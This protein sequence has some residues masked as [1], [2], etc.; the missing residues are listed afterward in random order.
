MLSPSLSWILSAD[1][2][3]H[4]HPALSAGGASNI[5]AGEA[6]TETRDGFSLTHLAQ[7]IK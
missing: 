2:M 7:G 6:G 1:I 4:S 3:D 5:T